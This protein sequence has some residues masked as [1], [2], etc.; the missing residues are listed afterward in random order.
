MATKLVQASNWKIQ[1]VTEAHDTDSPIRL[2]LE[3]QELNQKNGHT[4][5][6]WKFKL[7]DY[8]GDYLGDYNWEDAYVTVRL[9]D[10][11]A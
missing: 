3:I 6:D 4:M 1:H 10:L 11:F 8:K 7:L 2:F 5:K 9:G